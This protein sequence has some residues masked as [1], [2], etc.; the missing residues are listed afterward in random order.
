MKTK[1]D[2]GGSTMAATQQEDKSGPRTVFG[3]TAMRNLQHVFV[4]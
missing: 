3:N 2:T 4:K 1:G